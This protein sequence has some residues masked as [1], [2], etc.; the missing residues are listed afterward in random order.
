MHWGVLRCNVK[1]L[2]SSKWTWFFF[3]KRTFS[4]ILTHYPNCSEGGWIFK[5]VLASSLGLM[6]I[7]VQEAEPTRS[8]SGKKPVS[9][10]S[11]ARGRSWWRQYR[12]RWQRRRRRQ[13]LYSCTTTANKPIIICYSDW[14]TLVMEESGLGNSCIDWLGRLFWVNTIWKHCWIIFF[15]H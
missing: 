10:I 13:H 8:V 2:N 9:D 3:S 7:W 5:S 11:N 12:Q 1:Q 6:Q 14:Q 15:F 4:T